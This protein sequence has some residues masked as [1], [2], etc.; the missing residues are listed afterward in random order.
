MGI[1]IN[2]DGGAAEY[3]MEREA[4]AYIYTSCQPPGI[5]TKMASLPLDET[6]RCSFS[7]KS[8]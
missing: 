4:G 3:S 1:P 7:S 6:L 5:A 2:E 8:R